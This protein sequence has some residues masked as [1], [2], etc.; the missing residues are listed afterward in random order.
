MIFGRFGIRTEA[1]QLWQSQPKSLSLAMWAHKEVPNA[2]VLFL[3]RLR[4]RPEN[5]S[6]ELWAEIF[7]TKCNK[8]TEHYKWKRSQ[9]LEFSLCVPVCWVTNR[10]LGLRLA[11]ITPC[12]H[13]T[14]LFFFSFHPHKIRLMTLFRRFSL[15]SATCCL[16]P[17]V[18][19]CRIQHRAAQSS[20]LSYCQPLIN[21]LNWW[22]IFILFKSY[23]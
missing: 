14:I 6:L 8:E 12:R 1:A 4:I 2:A 15:L 21:V 5:W 17:S 7:L 18:L 13:H 10:P 23:F 9:A 22:C 16:C 11:L 3:E 20:L 19:L